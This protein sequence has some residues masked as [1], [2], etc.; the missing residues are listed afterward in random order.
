MEAIA[1][2]KLSKNYGR[3]NALSEVG[4]KIEPG[5]VIGLLGPNG[6]GKT[7]LMKVLTGYL[8]PDA[9]DVR[10]HGIDVAA[11]ALEAQRLI[12]YLPEGGPLYGEVRVQEDVEV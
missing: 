10:V 2:D 6:A 8:E 4:F 1:I 7:T 11:N 9:G 5:E 3:I 12:G